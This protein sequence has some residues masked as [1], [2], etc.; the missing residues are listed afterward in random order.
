M[1]QMPIQL[2][3]SP[4]QQQLDVIL[5]YLEVAH[6]FASSVQRVRSF[7]AQLRVPM[8]VG[9]MPLVGTMVLIHRRQERLQLVQFAT[10]GL[11]ILAIGPARFPSPIAAL[12]MSFSWSIHLLVVY[13]I[14]LLNL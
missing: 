8:P 14:V 2:V 6:G 5:A 9:R 1:Q 7:P 4:T 11:E 10:I 13:V 3:I 12:F